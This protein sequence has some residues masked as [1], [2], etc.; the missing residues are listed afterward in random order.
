MNVARSQN[1]YENLDFFEV[2]GP[3]EPKVA[4]SNPAARTI[5]PKVFADSDSHSL[6]FLG[7][8]RGR[9][10]FGYCPLSIHGSSAHVTSVLGLFLNVDGC[11]VSIIQ[12]MFGA[13][14]LARRYNISIWNHSRGHHSD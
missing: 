9:R 4:G 8:T 12:T 14:L 1:S 10:V 6:P 3:P 7:K 11:R 5:I 2:F 13:S